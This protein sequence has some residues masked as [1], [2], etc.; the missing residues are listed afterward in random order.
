[1]VRN[2]NLILFLAIGSLAAAILGLAYGS[3]SIDTWSAIQ[4]WA[5]QPR[6]NWHS[7]SHILALRV[8]R[9]A[10]A[11]LAGGAL[12]V[13][14]AVLQTILR[15]GLATPFTLG[16][17][18]AGSFGAFLWLAFPALG[19]T[20]LGATFLGPRL[21]AFIF[22]LGGLALVLATARRSRHADGL[23]LAGITL[24]FLFAAGTMLVRH[25]AAP[26]QLAAMDRWLM[27]SLDV[28]TIDAAISP[29]PWL[30]VGIFL[31]ARRASAL[32]Q[33]A[34]DEEMAQARGV[35]VPKVRREMLLGAGL[36]TAAIVARTGPIGFVGLLVPHA[37]RPFT[38]ARHAHL[39]AGCWFAGGGFLVLADLAARTLQITGRHSELPVGILTA[40]IGGPIFL[41][42][43]FR[44][45]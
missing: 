15:N 38:G 28:V 30:V 10:L 24:S 21:G 13:S 22:A 36:L 26:F 16:I 41:R 44:R 33:L 35:N 5:T 45:P 18:S 32:D 17:A 2:E 43:L 8:P 9:V 6:E 7:D 14:G 25:L 42:L 1:M 23:L 19:S 4:A 31:V 39:L 37:I 11:W 34:L 20:W 12:A 40:L 3:E 27:G 29:L